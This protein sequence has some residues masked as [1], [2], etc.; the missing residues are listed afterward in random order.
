MITTAEASDEESDFDPR[1]GGES[2]SRQ[3]SAIMR[4]SGDER[5]DGQPQA[6]NQPDISA[7]ASGT[8]PGG[9]HD[10]QAHGEGGGDEN[11]D[12]SPASTPQVSRPA[13]HRG[14]TDTPPFPLTSSA[15]V[16]PDTTDIPPGPTTSAPVTAGT[17]DIPTT[18]ALVA[19]GLDGLGQ[20]TPDTIDISPFPTTSA[21]TTPGSNRPTGRA[22]S[23]R[24]AGPGLGSPVP[25]P[26]PES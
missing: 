15:P 2:T 18:S 9:D 26:L 1:G 5:D 19:R 7:A 8:R 23:K 11:W 6:R 14:A 10:V 16:T 21:P 22:R 4:Q 3:A 24:V 12:P 13:S 25:P 20:D 17:T